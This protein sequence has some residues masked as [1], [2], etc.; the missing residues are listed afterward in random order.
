MPV[1]NDYYFTDI[2]KCIFLKEKVD[3]LIKFPWISE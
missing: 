1:Q 2:F 3:N